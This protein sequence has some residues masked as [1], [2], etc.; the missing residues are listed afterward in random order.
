MKS[1]KQLIDCVILTL[2]SRATFTLLVT[3]LVV[4][5]LPHSAGIEPKWQIQKMVSSYYGIG[6]HGRLAANG[7]SFNKEAL[8]AAHKT[9]PFGTLLRLTNPKTQKSVIVEVTD[10]GPYGESAGIHYYKGARDL[11]VSEGAAR[12]LGFAREGIATLLV[13]RLPSGHH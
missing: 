10:R 11:D 2:P 6:F 13:E 4:L 8:T 5:T 1:M 12:K 7:N 3:S 9:M